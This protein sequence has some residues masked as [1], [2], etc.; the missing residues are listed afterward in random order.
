[1]TSREVFQ[2][3]RCRFILKSLLED[4]EDSEDYSRLGPLHDEIH[5]S[6][7]QSSF[8]LSGLCQGI[9]KRILRESSTK[10]NMIE[11]D[12]NRHDS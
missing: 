1:M 3:V 5:V 10:R 6:F 12:S 4:L 2:H 8:K 9:K 7:H 11:R